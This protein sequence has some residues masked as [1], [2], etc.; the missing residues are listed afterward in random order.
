MGEYIEAKCNSSRACMRAGKNRDVNY[1][2][3]KRTSY[4]WNPDNINK[5]I[6]PVDCGIKMFPV[7]LTF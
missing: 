3:A 6:F 7:S 5:R 4:Y 1:R 2:E